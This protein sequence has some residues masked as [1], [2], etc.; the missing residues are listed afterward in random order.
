MWLELVHGNLVQNIISNWKCWQG[1]LTAPS[2]S[3]W[4]R[5]GRCWNLE[6]GERALSCRKMA[7]GIFV[8]VPQRKA[9]KIFKLCQHRKLCRPAQL[10][11]LSLNILNVQQSAQGYVSVYK[12]YSVYFDTH[13]LPML[14]RCHCPPSIFY[15]QTL[16]PCFSIVNESARFL[17]AQQL[18]SNLR[19]C[20]NSC[21]PWHLTDDLYDILTCCRNVCLFSLLHGSIFVKL[22]AQLGRKSWAEN[23]EFFSNSL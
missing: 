8:V 1:L 3:V 23:Q 21:G 20:D 19:K 18:Q 9:I 13:K 6:R 10:L 11:S 7:M 4:G 14:E 15:R 2:A 17:S 5:K 22:K 12:M 16:W